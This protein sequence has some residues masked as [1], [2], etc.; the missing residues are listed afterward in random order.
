MILLILGDAQKIWMRYDVYLNNWPVQTFEYKTLIWFT[1]E[2]RVM[3]FCDLSFLAKNRNSALH[4][5][6]GPFPPWMM[7]YSQVAVLLPVGEARAMH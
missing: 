2:I 4:D 5:G 7:V 3:C 1:P 6:D